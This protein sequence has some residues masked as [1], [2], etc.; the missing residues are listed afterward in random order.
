[1]NPSASD[2]FAL[3]ARAP[4]VAAPEREEF[5]RLVAD[6]ASRG[7]VVLRTCHRVELIGMQSA[8]DPLAGRAPSGTLCYTGNAALTHVIRLAVGLESV[9]VG[10]DQVLHQLRLAVQA[11]RERGGLPGE[12]DH[13]LDAALRAGRRARSWLPS[14]GGGLAELALRRVAHMSARGPVLV[15]G[16]GDM[17]RRAARALVARGSQVLVASRTI[18]RAAVLA[19]E[20][21]GRAVAF[22]PGPEELDAVAGVFVALAGSWP[23]GAAS[24]ASLLRREAWVADLSAPPAI[25]AR[26]ATALGRRLLT[27]DMLAQPIETQLSASMAKRLEELAAAT[28]ADFLAWHDRRDRRAVS[29]AL[30]ERASKVEATELAALWARLPALAPGDR[31]QVE[32]MAGRLAHRLLQEPFEQLD[33]DADGRRAVAVRDLF[34]L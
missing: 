14:R 34:R 1:V 30:A 31:R 4:A 2:T 11:A 6:G 7:A 33:R 5:G 8:L 28:L 23:V 32:R 22:D 9:V 18:E 10:E 12:L 26:I 3:V 19:G 20:V 27:V 17:G 25:E 15:V 13:L 29:K 24:A 16:A 21:G